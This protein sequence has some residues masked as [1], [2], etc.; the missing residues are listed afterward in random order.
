MIGNGT[1]DESRKEMRKSPGAPRAVAKTP[2]L[3][4]HVFSQENK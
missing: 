2:T 4:F 3:F 1:K